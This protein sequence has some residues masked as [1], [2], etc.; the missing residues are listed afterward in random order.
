LQYLDHCLDP[1]NE[2]VTSLDPAV[3]AA[4]SEQLPDSP[5]DANGQLR[6]VELNSQLYDQASR[7]LNAGR[8]LQREALFTSLT[9]EQDRN[10]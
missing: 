9:A 1:E 6:R 3:L 8:E 2:A 7:Q 4:I 10:A 5:Q